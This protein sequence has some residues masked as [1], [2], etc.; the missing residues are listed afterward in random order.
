MTKEFVNYTNYESIGMGIRVPKQ[1]YGY[2]LENT[3]R[4]TSIVHVKYF[5]DSM[6]LFKK[7]GF[8]RKKKEVVIPIYVKEDY[9]VEVK[10]DELT[11]ATGY[12]KHIKEQNPI[13][14]KEIKKYLDDGWDTPKLKEALRQ[15]IL[16]RDAF[17]KEQVP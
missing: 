1:H 10:S 11:R 9:K 2:V 6:V 4:G 3:K 16:E 15:H 5:L 12:I 7:F 17:E 13:Y 8:F 14:A